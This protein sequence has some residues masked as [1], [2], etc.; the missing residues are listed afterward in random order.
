MVEFN[1]IFALKVLNSQIE[2]FV[3][4]LEKDAPDALYGKVH[5]SS[6]GKTYT[7][8]KFKNLSLGERV[9]IEIA[10]NE[11]SIITNK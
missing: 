4:R 10:S 1:N 2:N 11:H 3:E 5:S 7:I 9:K 6:K 8:I